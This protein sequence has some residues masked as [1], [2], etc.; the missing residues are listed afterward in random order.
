VRGD[1]DNDQITTDAGDDS[2]SGG[3][4]NDKIDAGADNDSID[5]GTGNDT[6]TGGIGKD[7]ILGGTGTDRFVY[8][9]LADSTTALTGQDTISDFKSVEN[10][11]IN[12]TAIDA[13]TGG[14][15]DAFSFKGAA[16][17]T[18]VAGELH[19]RVV[20]SDSIVEGDVNGDS[21]AD[22]AIFVTGVTSF[23]AGDFLL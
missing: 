13:V 6:I 18:N 3:N 10:D 23:T 1:D 17:F 22:F 11:R 5:G 7:T 21:I 2:V 16:A 15:D 8:T 4:G 14:L 19:F 9:A 12:L 20:G